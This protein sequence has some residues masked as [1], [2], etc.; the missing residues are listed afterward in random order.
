MQGLEARSAHRLA[1]APWAAVFDAV[2]PR[3]ADVAR[4]FAAALA[5]RVP[6]HAKRGAIDL[7][8][9]RLAP[10]LRALEGGAVRLE[11]T[12]RALD[13]LLRRPD[14]DPERL[15]DR[16]RAQP[17]DEERFERR[18]ADAVAAVDARDGTE[19]EAVLSWAMGRVMPEF[20]GRRDPLEVR[21]RLARALGAAASESAS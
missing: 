6:F 10:L 2:A 18:V 12:D 15:L 8:A 13:D 21:D 9:E 11:A 5:K 14:V 4:R 17:D 20:L 16:Y 19:P 7:D 1:T 3:T